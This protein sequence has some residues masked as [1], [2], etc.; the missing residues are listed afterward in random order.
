[1]NYYEIVIVGAGA[2]GIAAAKSAYEAGC[3]SIL[4]IDRKKEMGGILLQ[5]AHRGFG[6]HLTGVE[7]TQK[8]LEQFPEKIQVLLDT[9]VLS[10]SPDRTVILSGVAIGFRKVS[11]DQLIMATGCLEITLG[12]LPVAGTRPEGVY[13]AGQVQ[14]MVNIYHQL[15]QGPVVILGSGDLG[16]IM[17]KQLVL[18]GIEVL[19][20]VEKKP[21]CGGMARNQRCLSEYNIPLIC[22]ATV[23][24]VLGEEYLTGVKVYN[25]HTEEEQV[26]PCKSLLVAVG[27]C[28]DQTLIYGLGTLNWIHLCGNCNVVHPMVDAVI[29]EGQ[30]AGITAWDKIQRGN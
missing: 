12:S 15:P 14:E 6:S 8:L 24:K 2:A 19:A 18:E 28:P 10:I 7:Y 23:T 13:T 3:N 29:L 17:A 1:M 27:L 16:L 20:M 30:K 22:S 5:C 9:T 25:F 21:K 26:I 11:F 4:L